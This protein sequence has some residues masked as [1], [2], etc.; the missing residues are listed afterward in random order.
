MNIPVIA[1]ADD[2]TFVASNKEELKE[3]ITI[4]QEF[5]KINDIEINSKKSELLVIG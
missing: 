3:I 4:A 5:Y 2:T 1:Y